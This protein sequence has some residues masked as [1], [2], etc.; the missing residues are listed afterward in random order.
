MVINA[1]PLKN[2]CP[3][4]NAPSLSQKEIV[5]ISEISTL[6]RP[7]PLQGKETADWSLLRSAV[8]VG[9]KQFRKRSDANG[10]E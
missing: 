9:A 6:R 3:E 8:W 7:G 4:I 2:P 1:S 10:K 5:A